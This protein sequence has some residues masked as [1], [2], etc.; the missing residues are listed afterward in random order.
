[1]GAHLGS[2]CRES[3]SAGSA[4]GACRTP[5]QIHGQKHSRP[6]CLSGD[7][8]MR[9]RLTVAALST[10]LSLVAQGLDPAALLKPGLDSWPTYN[11]DYS[12]KRFSSLRQI[13]RENV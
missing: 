6:L 11:G 9:K 8:E 5:H 13:S 7:V 10:T 3:R 1:M 2:Q 4:C 12:G